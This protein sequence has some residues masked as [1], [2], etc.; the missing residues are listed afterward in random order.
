MKNNIFIKL[1][2]S[3]GLICTVDT[4]NAGVMFRAF[5]ASDHYHRDKDVTQH[6]GILP[7]VL[8]IVLSIEN[9]RLSIEEILDISLDD[10]FII[11]EVFESIM[12]KIPRP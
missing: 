9:K 5:V 6:I 11:S 2:L 4:V 12:T 8:S 3:D 7:F 10:Y 1:K